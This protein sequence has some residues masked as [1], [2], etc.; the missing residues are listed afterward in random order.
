[1]TIKTAEDIR[2]TL[3]SLDLP[4]A[5]HPSKTVK[6]LH[7]NGYV[8]ST[9]AV[10]DYVIRKFYDSRYSEADLNISA[11][12]R[13]LRQSLALAKEDVISVSTQ[14]ATEHQVTPKDIQE[15]RQALIASWEK[16]ENASTASD[17]NKQ[18]GE[19][20]MFHES[21]AYF[22][23]AD[24]DELTVLLGRVLVTRKTIVEHKGPRGNSGLYS[25]TALIRAKELYK[26]ASPLSKFIPRL[27]LR[28]GG[29]TSIG[30][31]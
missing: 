19:R 15:A 4:D 23:D 5:S 7:I 31:F 3:A 25:K 1:M 24:N 22:T 13:L 9:G 6:F 11:Y 16:S 10:Y 12:R 26:A 17:E 2:N 20:L 27:N 29:V 18:Q 21:G 8:G 28:P 14:D 30:A